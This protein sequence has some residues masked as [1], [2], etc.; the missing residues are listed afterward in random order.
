VTADLGKL[1]DLRQRARTDLF[2]LSRHILGYD[3]QEDVHLPACAF[4][5][6]KDP[7]KPFAE[8]S[9]IKQRLW[10]DPRGHFKTTLDIADVIQ[11]ILCFPDIRILIM[12]GTR[13]LA[14][15]MLQECKNHFQMNERLRALFPEYAAPQKDWGTQDSFVV[16]ARRNW[17]L[18]EPTVSI[19]TVDSVKAGSHYDLIKCD[20]LVN[21]INAGTRDQ[22]EK[23]IKA[24]NYTTPLLE[25]FGYR[26]V[27][28]TR[29]DYSDL[30]GWLTDT[31]DG[32]TRIFRRACW[33]VSD[34][35]EYTLLFPQRA[36]PG[37][38]VVGFTLEMLQ[39]I[40]RDDPYLFNCQYLN[41]PS[42]IEKPDIT[43]EN[44][45]ARFV[46]ITSLPREGRTFITWDL[47][48]SSKQFADWSVGAVGRFDN[49]GRLFI[50]DL[51]RGRYSAYELVQ[52]IL[53]SARKY[54]PGAVG[55]EKS[56]GA[57]LIEPALIAAAR[58]HRVHMPL[59]WIPHPTSRKVERIGGLIALFKDNRLFFSEA[60]ADKDQLVREFVRFPRYKHDDIPD[61]CSMLLTYRNRTDI[62]WPAEEIELISAPVCAPELG[63]GLVG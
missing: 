10:L 37:G 16:P 31:N 58:E 30:Y 34:K 60:I 54:R 14:A 29:Y 23:T 9:E 53:M 26:D 11:W 43:E 59:D 41:D 46:P 22:I 32:K 24:F 51:I 35:G 20:D 7:R 8:Q 12:T 25:P 62:E 33:S 2:W 50:L 38:K 55:I 28:G 45:R 52:M 42:P 47:G 4:L 18:R 19:S 21:E 15:R 44:L 57:P 1:R 49:Q 48:F 13:D 56:G 3:F 39:T 40:Q 27:I 63:A 5:V 6:K 61:A 36:L 17:R